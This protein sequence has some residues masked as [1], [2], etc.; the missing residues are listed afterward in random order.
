[1]P[2]VS[3]VMPVFN[4]EKYIKEALNSIVN[5]TYQNMEILIIN[6]SS[7]DTSMDIV[8]AISDPRVVVI[9]NETNKGVAES[10]NRGLRAA[11]GKYVA[12]MDSDDIAEPNRI[13]LQVAFL[14]QNP[15]VS[16]CG[17]GIRF[18]GD[19]TGAKY[20]QSKSENVFVDLLIQCSLCHPTIMMRRETL[21]C[22]ELEYEDRYE[23][24]EDYRLWCCS[25]AY[26]EIVNL[27]EIGLNYRVHGQQVSNVYKE[28]QMRASDAIRTDYLRLHGVILTEDDSRIFNKACNQEDI[29]E[30]EFF[31]L[32][33]ICIEIA[34]HLKGNRSFNY[35]YLKYTLSVV[36]NQSY[37][38]IDVKTVS[39]RNRI[40]MALLTKLVSYTGILA[41]KCSR[42]TVR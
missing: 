17:M 1:M 8:A 26:G 40:R 10:L 33:K 9:N 5:Q 13:S 16:I 14:E 28:K 21:A 31:S 38:S 30:T 18:I 27:P 7:T 2:L 20:F 11:K 37:L 15:N 12:R 6:D 29:S 36:V 39:A 35:L 41:F 19:K 22:Y 4:A 25:T 24:A 42:L 34:R 32:I 3:V 23:K